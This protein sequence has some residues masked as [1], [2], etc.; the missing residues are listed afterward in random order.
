MPIWQALRWSDMITNPATILIMSDSLSGSQGFSN[1]FTDDPSNQKVICLLKN[2]HDEGK[3]ITSIWLL[4]HT[5]I[6]GNES[7][8]ESARGETETNTIDVII[9]EHTDLKSLFQKSW[10]N[11]WTNMSNHLRLNEE[12]VNRWKSLI[13]LSR[14]D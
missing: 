10:Q 5:D 2:L 7:A 14:Y 4:S 1:P 6:H 12:V 8:D 13:S 11:G 3:D 9:T